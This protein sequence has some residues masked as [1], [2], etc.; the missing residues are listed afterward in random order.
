MFKTGLDMVD[1]DVEKMFT[2]SHTYTH[3]PQPSSLLVFLFAVF[4][5]L[6]NYIHSILHTFFILFLSVNSTFKH[7]IHRAYK[8]YYI[9][10]S[11]K[12]Y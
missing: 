7:S 10:I 8:N 4:A 2:D 5:Q 12:E 1:N 6:K 9:L 3:N 11:N